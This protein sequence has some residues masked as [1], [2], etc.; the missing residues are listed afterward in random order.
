MQHHDI[1]TS[2]ASMAMRH[3]QVSRLLIYARLCLFKR[4]YSK[5]NWKIL[6]VAQLLYC[7]V[8]WILFPWWWAAVAA[9]RIENGW[10]ASYCWCLVSERET[11][12]HLFTILRWEY[13]NCLR[14]FSRWEYRNSLSLYIYNMTNLEVCS[15]Y[16]ITLSILIIYLIP[17]HC[18][19]LSPRST[20]AVAT[21][22]S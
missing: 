17:S 20:T 6:F 16:T 7:F 3:N 21:S 14:D 10:A 8:C 18:C 11:R 4:Y 13:R 22:S 19:R 2:Q 15:N 12:V 9:N 1:I 5:F